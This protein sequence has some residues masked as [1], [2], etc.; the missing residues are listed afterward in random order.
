[1]P[2]GMR[3]QLHLRSELLLLVQLQMLYW[4]IG[5]YKRIINCQGMLP[6]L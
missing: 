4:F 3:F 1:M 6:Q 5:S 2:G